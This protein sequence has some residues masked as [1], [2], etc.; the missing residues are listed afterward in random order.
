MSDKENTI[1]GHIARLH[2]MRELRPYRERATALV[3]VIILP[4]DEAA[5]YW[6]TAAYELLKVMPVADI[7]MNGDDEEYNWRAAVRGDFIADTFGVDKDDKKKTS[8]PWKTV[9][10]GNKRTVLICKR[11]DAEVVLGSKTSALADVVADI[12]EID[13]ALVQ[14]AVKEVTDS[15]ITRDEA[16]EL[17]TLPPDTRTALRK[18]GRGIQS[19]L[20]RMR[21]ME[22]TKKG[23]F[24]KE[25]APPKKDEDGPRLEDLHGYGPAMD[26]AMELR[27]DL[28]DY[29]DGLIP[30]SDVDNGVLLSGPPGCGKTTFGAALA[31]SLGAHFVTGSYST[32][33]GQGGGHQGDL[34]RSMRK[35]FDEARKNA[36]SV[37]LIDEIDNFPQRGGT[38]D[39]RYDDW[40]RGVV[41]ALLEQLDGAVE[42]EAVIVVGATNNPEIVDTAVKR[43]GRLERHIEIPLPDPKARTKILQYHLQSN[44]DVSSLVE[45]TDGF[46]GADLER[47][48]KDARRAARRKRVAVSIDHVASAMPETMRLGRADLLSTA[49]HELGH[50]V[51]GIALEHRRL[52][53]IVVHREVFVTSSQQAAGYAEFAT[54]LITRK[55]KGWWEREICIYLGSVASESIFFGGHCDG[56]AHDL[57][58]ATDAA[59]HMTAVAGFGKTLASEGMGADLALQRA[60]NYHIDPQVDA[61]LH[62][63]LLRASTIVEQYRE[64]IEELAEDLVAKGD[65]AGDV[66]TKAVLNHVRP[67]QLALTV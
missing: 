64:V 12:K 45:R 14:I 26:W 17:L 63:Q 49:I 29:A 30:W 21:V 32:W 51:V 5:S 58:Q 1:D 37:L 59:T 61:I 62:E 7:E 34:I 52:K 65:L 9:S 42:R 24:V 16:A 50:A 11:G 22:D 15:E 47:I 54:Q 55:D 28:E 33:L 56:A 19:V 53:R 67:V 4:T 20:A 27:R 44:L 13:L 66:V 48:A 38:G 41:N 3:M 36:P 57:R 2:L 43:S 18:T 6:Q 40:N 46:S 10:F 35:A 31:K 23:E 8:D 60:R 39:A 25:D